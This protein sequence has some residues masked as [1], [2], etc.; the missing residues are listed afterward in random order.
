M[1]PILTVVSAGIHEGE[2]RTQESIVKNVRTVG[3]SKDDN[4][5]CGIEAWRKR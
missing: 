3:A 4:V 5:Q 1:T 2:S